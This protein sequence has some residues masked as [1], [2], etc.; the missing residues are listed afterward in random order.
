MSSPSRRGLGLILDF[1]KSPPKRKPSA[2]FVHHRHSVSALHAEPFLTTDSTADLASSTAWTDWW[3]SLLS[4]SNST[5]EEPSSE[6]TS[7][8]LKPSPH[9]SRF[10]FLSGDL[11]LMG[12]FYGSYLKNAT[13]SIRDWL[14]LDVLLGFKSTSISLPLDLLLEKND[15]KHV[16]DT[17]L[18]RIGLIDLCSQLVRELKSWE[19]ESGGSFRFDQFAYDWRQDGQTAAQELIECVEKKFLSNG[20]KPVTI[21][22]RKILFSD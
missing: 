22:A 9:K 6:A 19:A 8:T 16:A 11:V 10:S 20:G 17:M 18:E 15:M 4:P 3:K 2:T 7:G 5:S 13:T 21:V 1:K 12:G 14:T